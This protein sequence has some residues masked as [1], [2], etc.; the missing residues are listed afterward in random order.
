M[1]KFFSGRLSS[2]DALIGNSIVIFLF[3]FINIIFKSND[4]IFLLSLIITIFYL[5][6]IGV[7]HCHD[8]DKP[9]YFLLLPTSI[10]IFLYM[11]D[12]NEPNKYGDSPSKENRIKRI[13]IPFII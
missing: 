5:F 13:F 6:S 12:H 2:I 4:F 3:L 10:F 7:R 1:N 9:W 8:L 11:K